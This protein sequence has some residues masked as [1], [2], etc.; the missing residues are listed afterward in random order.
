MNKKL[1][2]LL[3]AVL[4]IVAMSV[5]MIACSNDG[6][7]AKKGSS[8]QT[9][10]GSVAQTVTEAV[11]INEKTAFEIAT[12]EAMTTDGVQA[13]IALFDS[14][15]GDQIV[16]NVVSLDNTGKLFR[17]NAPTTGYT[18]G[19]FYTLELLDS[20]LSFVDFKA[21]KLSMYVVAGNDTVAFNENVTYLTGGSA[22]ISN[23][24]ESGALKTFEFDAAAANQ[25]LTMGQIILVEDVNTGDFTAYQIL[26]VQATDKTGVYTVAYAAPSYE[27]V[28]DKL[29]ATNTAVLGQDGTVTIKEDK[30]VETISEQLSLFGFNAGIA[31]F[32]INPSLDLSNKMVTINVAVTLPDILGDKDGANNLELTLNFGI[33]TKIVVET[34]ISIGQLLAAKD[35]GIEL[36]TRFDNTLTFGVEVKDG[37]SLAD[38]S[39]LDAVLT[40]IAAMIKGMNEDDISIDIFNWV[41]PIGN[42]VADINFDVNL[43]MNFNFEGKIGV[44]STSTAM[45][46]TR[47]FFNPSTEE[48]DFSVVDKSFSFDSVNVAVEA[49][50]AV[51]IG[52][53]A[54]I[55]FELLGGVISVGVGAE[56]GNFNKV[57]GEFASNNLLEEE[58]DFIYGIYFEGG[59]YYDAK[60]LYNVA[61]LTSGSI[62]FLGGRQEKVL[63]TAGSRYVVTGLKDADMVIS[64]VARD[65]VIPCTYRDIVANTSVN[66]FTNIIDAKKIQLVEDT[67]G[68]VQIVDGKISLTDAGVAAASTISDYVITVK[69]DGIEAKI[70]IN[71]ANTVETK[72]GENAIIALD[73]QDIG[74]TITAAY[75]DGTTV[76]VAYDGVA[77]GVEIPATAEGAIIVYADGEVIAIV[78]IVK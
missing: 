16:S 11:Q 59:I 14:K 55:K 61:K 13:K 20:R 53:D 2:T 9:K 29:E 10:N 71:V 42:G 69:A 63:Y 39:A 25:T 51:Y 50:A 45:L 5:C 32:D 48:K 54:A 46:K 19:G 36:V 75:L 41:I 7:A 6:D 67:K 62:S 44:V 72:V 33:Q 60:F 77:S 76:V 57:Y 38:Q 21:T 64:T 31:R 30:I 22:Y 3:I 49:N 12:S 8:F 58:K 37:V 18:E 15:T 26:G 56:V 35:N 28:Y 65:I 24:A 17:L 27:E 47:I 66:E 74:K 52:I 23:F 1:W 40:K 73:A 4:L 43:D 78:N 70:T 68:Y 34:E